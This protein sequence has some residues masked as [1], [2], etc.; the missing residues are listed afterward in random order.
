MYLAWFSKVS[1]R[2]FQVFIASSNLGHR[3]VSHNLLV[4][5]L[6]LSVSTGVFSTHLYILAMVKRLSL[7]EVWRAQIVTLHGEEYTESDIA[8]KLHCSKTVVHNAIMT[9]KA[10]SMFQ[11]R[12]KSGH[13]QNTM[14]RKDRSMR[15]IVMCS[16]KSFCKTI[17]A[18]LC[19]RSTA[20]RSSTV[21]RHLSKEF[22]LKSHRP[23]RKPHLTPVI[24]LV[25]WKK[26]VVFWRMHL[27]TV[28]TLPHAH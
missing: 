6:Q 27:I 28:C 22:G 25:E 2:S 1:Q 7:T 3:T 13:P 15:L 24:T 18:I 8:D 10:D 26:S 12:K 4:I 17:C 16:P 23:T 20:I 19:L 5:C 21:L 9:F 14:V 11:D